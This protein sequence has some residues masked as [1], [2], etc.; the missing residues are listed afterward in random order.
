[1]VLL[2]QCSGNI[3]PS[4]EN[5]PLS[6]ILI[7]LSWSLRLVFKLRVETERKNID[8]LCSNRVTFEWQ[9]CAQTWLDCS[10]LVN[11]LS[12]KSGALRLAILEL[13]ESSKRWKSSSSE[14]ESQASRKRES[15]VCPAQVLVEQLQL[16][17]ENKLVWAGNLKLI[18]MRLLSFERQQI[19]SITSKVYR[20]NGIISQAKSEGDIKRVDNYT[21]IYIY[22]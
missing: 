3:C 10:S 15:R 12:G 4:K 16:W 13:R 8:T 20:A 14:P 19:Y 22:I 6:I 2:S 9:I 5:L 11:Q 1:M 21:H 18:R 7:A 17:R